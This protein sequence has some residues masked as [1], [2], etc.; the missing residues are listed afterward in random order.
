MSVRFDQA[1]GPQSLEA[2]YPFPPAPGGIRLVG[3]TVSV[4]LWIYLDEADVPGVG[5]QSISGRAT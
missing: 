4:T 1:N 2:I 3:S 5:V